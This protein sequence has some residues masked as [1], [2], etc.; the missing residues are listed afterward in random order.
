MILIYGWFE[1][2]DRS[3]EDLIVGDDLVIMLELVKLIV[4]NY[5]LF[6]AFPLPPSSWFLL[7]LIQVT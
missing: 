2:G 3:F 5:V 4:N 7:F 1:N 6:S